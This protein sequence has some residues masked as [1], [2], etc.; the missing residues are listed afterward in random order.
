VTGR[1]FDHA[2]MREAYS[3][4]GMDPRTWISYA[5]VDV[6]DPEQGTETV[7]FDE[8]D[9]QLYVNVTLSPMDTPL[10]ARVGMLTA[11]SGEALYFPFCGG[12]E[13]LV[14]IPEGNMRAGA[15]I[16]ARLNN[17]YDG[18]PFDSVGGADPKLNAAAI[19]RTRT[20][21]TIESGASVQIR[22]AAAGAM[23][24]LSAEGNV[25]LRDAKANVLQMSPDVF[26]FQTGDGGTFM[27]LDLSGDRFNMQVNQTSFTLAGSSAAS[28]VP[29]SALV[30]PLAFTM[31]AGGTAPDYTA[32]EHVT[33]TEAVAN[34]FAQV[35]N[36]LG[37][38][39]NLMP[40]PLTG[41]ALGALLVDPL[42]S[43]ST[44]AAGLTAAAAS[45]L[46][47]AVATAITGIFAAP[48]PKIPG[49]PGLGQTMPSVGCAGFLAG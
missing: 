49:V 47:P 22:S 36:V 7:E 5:R 24:L 39:L 44:L 30:S 38:A 3:G 32:V 18:F 10:R 4:P 27:Q 43:T 13:V 17:A 48:I 15:V 42:F 21:L 29:Y 26:G 6:P 20:A 41:P 1:D 31:A 34:I 40:G 19:F 11:G 25:T 28:G 16:I 33:T 8:D 9:G 12:E 23:L 37:V 46:N 45:T 14:A 35:M 2:S